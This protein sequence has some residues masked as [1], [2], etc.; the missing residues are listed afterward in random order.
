MIDDKESNPYYDYPSYEEF[1]E[2]E[3]LPAKCAGVG[4]YWVS[5][6]NDND[7]GIFP[8]FYGPDIVS[9]AGGGF[10]LPKDI[11]FPP[12]SKY[13]YDNVHPI[14]CFNEDTNV[15]SWF[16]IGND[17][18]DNW[19]NYPE[20]YIFRL[21]INSSDTVNAWCP[22]PKEYWELNG[23]NLEPLYDHGLYNM[24]SKGYK[25][26]NPAMMPKKK[27]RYITRVVLDVYFDE[28]D[29]TKPYGYN[30]DHDCGTV[31]DIINAIEEETAASEVRLLTCVTNAATTIESTD[32][33]V[34]H[35]MLRKGL[36]E[37]E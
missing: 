3:F 19:N 22:L 16:S 9:P 36:G 2:Y 1:I 17:F 29:V 12:L 20:N 34:L 27:K 7:N 5:F 28:D 30:G 11:T 14:P 8:Y 15:W 13:H 26:D 23:W 32:K 31:F 35:P 18:L 4:H 10:T 33:N 25:L 6:K 37:L 24:S 21:I